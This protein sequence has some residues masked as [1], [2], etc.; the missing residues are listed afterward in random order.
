MK[1]ELI[2]DRKIIAGDGWDALPV[3]VR[4]LDSKNRPVETAD[5]PI[6]FEIDGPGSI[7]GLGN[8]D[9]NSHEPEKGN[10]RNLYNGLAQV[11][12]QSKEDGS[13]QITLTA[14]ADGLADGKVSII[15]TPAKPIPFVAP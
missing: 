2:P 8:G 3:T 14:K 13:K 10:K 15:V 1:I 9:A 7:I 4:V 6:H 11:I 5:L 12:L